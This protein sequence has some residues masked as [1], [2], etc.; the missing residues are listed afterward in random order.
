MNKHLLGIFLF[1]ASL[2][3]SSIQGGNILS[4]YF[5]GSSADDGQV[6]ELEDPVSASLSISSI[7]GGLLSYATELVPDHEKDKF[8][9]LRRGGLSAD[10]DLVSDVVAGIERLARENY[11]AFLN[12]A[13]YADLGGQLMYTDL[14][15]WERYGVEVGP[16][17]GSRFVTL[18]VIRACI[19]SEGRGNYSVQNPLKPGEGK[20]GT[21][22]Q[23]LAG[24]ILADEHPKN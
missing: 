14:V 21:A 3:M 9:E 1:S 12:L 8:V 23:E 18:P 5:G 13:R 2:G 16:L 4:S 17:G 19:V 24:P 15:T 6:D 22:A 20:E 7:Q 10:R 11:G